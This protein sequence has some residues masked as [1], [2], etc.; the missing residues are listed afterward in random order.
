MNT[1]TQYFFNNFLLICILSISPLIEIKLSFLILKKTAH[2]QTALLVFD[3]FNKEAYFL[4][5]NYAKESSL[6]IPQ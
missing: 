3:N 6:T 2:T 1:H 4:K 5:K